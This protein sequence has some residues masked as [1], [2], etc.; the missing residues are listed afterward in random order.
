MKG[1]WAGVVDVVLS[2]EST[3]TCCLYDGDKVRAVGTMRL[4]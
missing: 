2:R 4:L 3:L 1:G